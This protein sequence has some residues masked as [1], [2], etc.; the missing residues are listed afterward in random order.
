MKCVNAGQ[1]ADWCRARGIVFSDRHL[2]R[3]GYDEGHPLAI[4]IEAPTNTQ[5]L[6]A[7]GYVILAT[8]SD[9][10]RSFEGGLLWLNDWDIWS[11]SFERVGH[12][13]AKSLR[14]GCHHGAI[15]DAPGHLFDP[16]EFIQAQALLLLPMVFQWDA[17][18]IP[19]NGQFLVR[20]GHHGELHL[21]SR[22][23]VIADQLFS[24]FEEGEWNPRE[25]A[26]P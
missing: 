22:D 15:A 7:L 26:A 16:G 10:E 20:L 13:L 17:H 1:A 8:A 21:I 6:L 2:R 14:V 25:V 9:D 19:A 24:R 11:E 4:S 23:R 5:R 18:F 12:W 3:L